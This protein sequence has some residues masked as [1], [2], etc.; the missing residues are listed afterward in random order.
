MDDATFEQVQ[1][2]FLQHEVF[3]VRGS[4]FDDDD[5]IRFS[6]RFGELRKL[7]LKHF[8]R[9]GKPEIFVVSNIRK[10]ATTSASTMPG[11]SGT[12]TVPT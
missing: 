12:P 9:K 4:A 1:R 8:L 11:S 7:E 2:A 10:M 3:V 5:H 6:A